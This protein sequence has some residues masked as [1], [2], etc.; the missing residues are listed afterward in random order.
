MKHRVLLFSILLV[1]TAATVQAQVGLYANFTAQHVGA[2]TGQVFGSAG[3]LS[4][5]KFLYGPTFGIYNDFL[6][7]GPLHVGAD[8]R[9]SILSNGDA[10]LNSGLAGLRVAVKAP[11]LPIKPYVQ[12]S[13]GVAGFN[14]GRRQALTNSFT[15]EIDGG[16]DLTFLPRLDWRLVEVGGGALT[17]SGPGANA[18]NGLFHISTGLVFRLPF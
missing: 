17:S 3:D 12:A 4:N 1:L 16:V 13:A 5:G 11:V 8:I 14:Y 10:K 15:Y 7:A 18:G 9:G 2:A 6:H